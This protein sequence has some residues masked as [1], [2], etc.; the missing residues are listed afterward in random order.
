MRNYKTRQQ[1]IQENKELKALIEKLDDEL[2]KLRHRDQSTMPH[3]K[4]FPKLSFKGGRDNGI[5]QFLKK[6]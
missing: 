2:V 3:N 4:P 1:L 6:K 5:D